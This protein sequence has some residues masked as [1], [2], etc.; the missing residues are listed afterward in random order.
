M[1]EGAGD[2]DAGFRQDV[3]LAQLVDPMPTLRALAQHTGTDL[4]D[5]VHLALV[6]YAADGAE[7]LLALGPAS[8]RELVRARQAG[9]WARVGGIVD[10]LQAGLDSTTWRH[11]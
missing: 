4:E 3:A 10:W 1:A 2:R 11:G 9:D 7:A 5:L 8:L 6:R